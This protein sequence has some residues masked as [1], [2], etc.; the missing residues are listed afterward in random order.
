MCLKALYFVMEACGQDEIRTLCSLWTIQGT[1]DVP[2]RSSGFPF[3]PF[4][5]LP[6]RSMSRTW[7]IYPHCFTH[8]LSHIFCMHMCHNC[9]LFPSHLS[10]HYLLHYPTPPTFTHPLTLIDSPL[11]LI[12]V[13]L[14]I[15]SHMKVKFY[16]GINHQTCASIIEI[17]SSIGLDNCLTLQL[18]KR[19]MKVFLNTDPVIQY[20]M[21]LMLLFIATNLFAMI[22]YFL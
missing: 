11:Q 15:H 17:G 7:L 1:S 5:S 14:L 20:R 8:P 12:R 3:H 21:K 13:V 19:L 22:K 9:L 4:P 6:M 16:Q 2:H 18:L 10:H